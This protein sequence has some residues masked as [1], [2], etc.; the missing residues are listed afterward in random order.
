M[1]VL[2]TGATGFVGG[3]VARRL[4]RE[5]HDVRALARPSADIER[6][7][8]T[9]V[10]VVPGD[11]RDAASVALAVRGC[12]HV[13]HLAAAKSGSATL[14]HEVNVRGTENVL[15]AARESGVQ[16]VVFGSTLGVHGFVVGRPIDERTPARPNTL[17][18]LT[19]WRAEEVVRTAHEHV[20]APVVIARIS[21]VIGR[22]A[23]GWLPLAQGIVTGRMRLIGDGTNSIDLV[24]ISDLVDGLVRCALA[25]SIEGRHYVLGA[26]SPS[27]VAGFATSIA[28]A[29]GVPAPV[30]G[31]PAAPFRL[32][33]RAAALAFR[34]KGFASP[35][36]HSREPL[37]AD[38]RADSARA[39]AELGYEPRASVEDA[40][41][42]MVDGFVAAGQLPGR[43]SA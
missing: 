1:R 3:A 25:P 9:G 30:P 11:V 32:A 38:K 22:G 12:S 4:A 31:L 34:L 15:D 37:V 33:Q 16:R 27:T 20:N 23:R 17:Y 18:R 26:G 14:M 36:V 21:S 13:I 2:V 24:P 7:L 8:E 6:L 43:R 41:S 39:R 40:I 29:L 28:G 5:G 42:A 19:K 35:F 10:E